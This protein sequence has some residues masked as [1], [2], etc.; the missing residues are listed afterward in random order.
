MI[1][2]KAV[3]IVWL[4]MALSVTAPV[5]ASQLSFVATH[6]FLTSLTHLDTN[7]PISLRNGLIEVNLRGIGRYHPEEVWIDWGT[8]DIVYGMPASATASIPPLTWLQTT[9][10]TISYNGAAGFTLS[11]AFIGHGPSPSPPEPGYLEQWHFY[12]WHFSFYATYLAPE[13][14]SYRADLQDTYN[15]AFSLV[16]GAGSKYPFYKVSGWSY[17]WLGLYEP[18]NQLFA[19]AEVI[20]LDLNA[21]WPGTLPDFKLLKENQVINLSLTLDNIPAG[22]ELKLVGGIWAGQSGNTLVPLP[23]SLF[24]AGPG[25]LWLLARRRG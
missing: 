7:E 20:D 16:Q 1:R 11:H 24:L 25:L 18:E 22:A 5:A 6:N 13:G 10:S 2:P 8:R 3:M 4:V 14:G 17:A 21:P 23:A 9:Q 19:Y 15:L 12:P